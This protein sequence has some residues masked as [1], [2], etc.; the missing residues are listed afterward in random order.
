MNARSYC[1]EY[2]LLSDTKKTTVNNVGVL[3]KSVLIDL[4]AHNFMHAKI[5]LCARCMHARHSERNL[6]SP[7]VYKNGRQSSCKQKYTFFY[8][9][10]LF[11]QPSHWLFIFFHE[12][13]LRF[14]LG[15][16]YW[17]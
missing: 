4:C 15:V 8:K 12:F 14:C 16:A 10:T 2:Y 3:V 7:A 5:S 17:T 1:A 9:A 6:S 11:F 13:T